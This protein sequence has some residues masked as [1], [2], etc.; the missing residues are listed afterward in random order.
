M[1]ETMTGG[2]ACERI[3]FVAQVGDDD[4]YLCHCRMCQRATGSVSIAYK[5]IGKADVRWDA[6]P[7]WYR[8]S[9]IAVRPFCAACGTSLGFAFPDSDTMDLTVAAFDDPSRFVPT[10]HFG[11]E[12]MHRAWL[13]TEGLP[14]MRSEENPNVARR[15]KA[16][17][18][19]MPD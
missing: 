13:D 6:E 16:A 9:P 5:A 4:A 15:W 12:S 19:G 1:P 7:D 2:C 10:R 18:G 11:V 14:E 3:R 8:S 17:T